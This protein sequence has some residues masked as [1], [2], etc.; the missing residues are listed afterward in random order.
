MFFVKWYT[1]GM[2]LNLNPN[3]RDAFCQK[4]KKLLFVHHKNKIK[5]KSFAISVPPPPTPFSYS[6]HSKVEG[7]RR[8]V[9][10]K[11]PGLF[12]LLYMKVKGQG[13]LI[14][15]GGIQLRKWREKHISFI[16]LPIVPNN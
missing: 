13:K 4:L 14:L 2:K 16:F 12:H 5:I 3:N 11:R 15:R 8:K 7:E 6:F 9:N 1:I 10:G